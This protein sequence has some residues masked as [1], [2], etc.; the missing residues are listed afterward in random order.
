MQRTI[1]L[2]N[3][4]Y[5]QTPSR[6]PP[7]SSL[8]LY[9]YQESRK[10]RRNKYEQV[11][12]ID[13]LTEYVDHNTKL[14]G[15]PEFRLRQPLKE[16]H[17]HLDNQRENKAIIDI[18]V[19]N[20]RAPRAGEV[21]EEALCI[22]EGAAALFCAETALNVATRRTSAREKRDAS[23]C[24]SMI[25]PVEVVS[26]RREE[27]VGAAQLGSREKWKVRRMSKRDFGQISTC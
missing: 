24:A 14:A 21:T 8:P 9:K 27:M 22:G 13:R 16:Q 11:C 1:H 4:S 23:L 20:A 26:E 19:A 12:N 15:K 18:R 3:S 10:T 7:N 25:E 5:Q 6:A 2:L 17:Q